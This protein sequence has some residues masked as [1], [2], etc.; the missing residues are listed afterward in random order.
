MLEKDQILKNDETEL[1]KRCVNN[2]R[3]AQ[4]LLFHKYSKKMMAV[5][6]RYSRNREDAEDVLNDGFMR[7]F[8]KLHTFQAIGSLEG[9]IRKIVVNTAIDHYRKALKDQQNLSIENAG[10]VSTDFSA[11]D[12]IHAKELTELIRKL[13]EGSRLILNLYAIEGYSHK[14]IAQMLN[15][16]EGTSKSQLSRGK[17]LLQTWINKTISLQTIP[18]KA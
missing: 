2:E 1:V 16:S 18:Q 15:I 4:N 3:Q 17:T 6:F 11:L 8:D 7:V 13:P 9:W 14:E 5:C 12:G 10:N